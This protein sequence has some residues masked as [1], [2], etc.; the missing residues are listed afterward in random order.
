MG[1]HLPGAIADRVRQR[2]EPVGCPVRRACNRLLDV[3][4]PVGICVVHEVEA[5]TCELERFFAGPDPGIPESQ[6]ASCHEH[7][8]VA[9]DIEALLRGPAFQAGSFRGALLIQLIL[10]RQY[11][12]LQEDKTRTVRRF[13]A[14]DR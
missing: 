14:F 12:A 4:L 5:E 10:V 6:P 3:D 13:D 9:V 11:E 7:P 1:E 8:T 2:D